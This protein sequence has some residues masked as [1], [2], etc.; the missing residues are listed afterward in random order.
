MKKAPLQIRKGAIKSYSHDRID[1]MG[2]IEN[3][4]EVSPRRGAES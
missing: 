3:A 4:W 2:A 1:I